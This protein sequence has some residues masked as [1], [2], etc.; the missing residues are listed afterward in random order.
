MYLF[1]RRVCARTG[2]IGEAMAWAT[3]ITERARQVS[4]LE[5]SLFSGVYGPQV[6]TLVWSA[7]VPDLLALETATDKLAVDEGFLQEANKGQQFA[8]EG[9]D[10]RLLQFIHPQPEAMAAPSDAPP[11]GYAAVISAVCAA[12]QYSRGI[13][14]GVQLA[15]RAG[16]ITGVPTSFLVDTTGTYGRVNWI[17]GYADAEAIDRANQTLTADAAWVKSVDDETA[18]VYLADP[19]ATQQLLYRRVL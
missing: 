14:L 15:V 9:P 8:P 2:G 16:E 19:S 13:E 17:T 6:G 3:G 11:F 18:G 12:G 1:T 7:V 5:V 10:D 4:G